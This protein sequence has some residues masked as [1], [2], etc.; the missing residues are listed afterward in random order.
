MLDRRAFLA[1][2]V[3]AGM[4]RGES[5]RTRRGSFGAVLYS[6]PI[7]SRDKAFAEPLAF[8][9]YCHS[10]GLDGIQIDFGRLSP[11]RAKE[12]RTSAEK[13]G[14]YVEGSIRP[15]KDKSDVERFDTE[16]AISSACGA[17]VVRTVMLGGRRYETFHSAKEYAAFAER[18]LTSLRLAEPVLAKRKAT[19]AVENHKDFR[20]DELID[21]LKAIGSEHIGVCVDTGNSMA[22]LERVND[23][24]D[25]LAPY[26]AAC[27]LKDMGVEESPDGFLLAEVPLG[28][29]FLDLRRIVDTLRKTKPKLHFSLEMITRD[30]L[31]IPCLTDDYWSTLERVPGRDLARILAMVKKNTA[32]KPLRLISKLNKEEQ[33]AIEESNVRRSIEFA[34]GKLGL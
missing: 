4:G 5:P 7:H 24:V 30:P 23:T 16:I 3:F 22:L 33:L 15:P 25:S 9:N 6:F 19:L 27:H 12:L 32:K 14:M 11:D 28:D 34:R 21:K 17:T 10:L 13:H 1:A 26:A 18:A 8:L 20:T 29:G 31:R 2:A